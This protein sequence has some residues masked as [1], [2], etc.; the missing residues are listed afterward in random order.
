VSERADWAYLVEP[1]A[2]RVND[3]PFD[4]AQ[5]GAG[6]LLLDIACSS[7]TPLASRPAGAP[8]YAGWMPPRH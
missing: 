1:Y 7:G 4:R 2:R 6:I 5:V 8:R 3:A